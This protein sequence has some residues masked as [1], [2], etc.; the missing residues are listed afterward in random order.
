M[1]AITIAE[2]EKF[3]RQ[4]SVDVVF[5]DKDLAKEIEILKEFGRTHEI[6]L[7]LASIQIG[8][9]KKLVLIKTKTADL[10]I[11]DEK[12]WMILINPQIISQSGR[13]SSWEACMSCLPHVSLVER[14]YQM[15]IKYQNEKG[16]EKTE[17]FEGFVCTV[18]SHELD[19]LDGI[20]HMDRSNQTLQMSSEERAMWRKEHPYKIY[21][22]DC[23]FQYNPI[24]NE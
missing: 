6:C 22:K 3:L 2:N 16:D 11:M 17:H 23:E 12:D 21:S 20:F 8:I 10:K 13:T 9:P 18:L 24:E 19:H 7:A 1:E 14:P 15:D 5:P 4:K